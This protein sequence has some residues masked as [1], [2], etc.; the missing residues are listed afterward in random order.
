M[1]TKK[2]SWDIIIDGLEQEGVEYVFGLPGSPSTLY[3]S[4]YD[5]KTE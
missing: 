3:G 1:G 5:S 4:L 2:R